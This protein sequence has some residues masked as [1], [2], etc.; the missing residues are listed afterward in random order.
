MRIIIAGGRDFKDYH[1]LKAK[2]FAIIS[3]RPTGETIE[4]ISGK[5]DGADT[6]GET[7]AKE[8][9]IPITEFPADWSNVF[10][11]PLLIK[12]SKAG[13]SYNALAGYVRNE[14]MAKYAKKDKGILIAFWDRKSRGTK[15]MIDIAKKNG[16]KTYVYIYKEL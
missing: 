10:D 5:A 16:L 4:I 14:K 1:M 8:L 7:F 6:L 9:G 13:R 3:Q 12:T 11:R 15:H 2:C